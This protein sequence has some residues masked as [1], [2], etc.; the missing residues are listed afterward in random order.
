MTSKW[1]LNQSISEHLFQRTLLSQGPPDWTPIVGIQREGWRHRG[2]CAA[3]AAQSKRCRVWPT[4]TGAIEEQTSVIVKLASA[5]RIAGRPHRRRRSHE[6]PRLRACRVQA[7]DL[8]S[9]QV[10]C[11][12]AR[13]VGMA[14]QIS[15]LI[16][17]RLL[18][19]LRLGRTPDEKDVEIAALRHQL[20][21]LARQV[22]RPRYSPAD[23][24]LLATRARLLSRERWA[25]FLATP[26]TLLRWHRELI[27]RSWTYPRDGRRRAQRPGR[28]GRCPRSSPGP[29]EP[30]LGLPPHRGRV[31][32]APRGRL[33][34]ERAQRAR[35]V[36]AFDRHR[37]RLGHRGQSSSEHRLQ[38]RSRATS[39]ASARSRCGG[40]MCCSSS[41]SSVVRSS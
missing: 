19:V 26:A 7:Q 37:G 3:Y 4:S 21:V 15:F 36:T 34:D 18:D 38:A 8:G 9:E 29:G 24:A 1:S 35:P 16:V 41:T 12:R 17:R 32:Q 39:S 28:R 31:P 11:A 23:R 30:S 33:G 5:G 40:F 22:A 25:A 13:I 14:C 6:V 2:G 10:C 27:A 20:A